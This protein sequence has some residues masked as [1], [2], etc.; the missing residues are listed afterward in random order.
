MKRTGDDEHELRVDVA[1]TGH[2]RKRLIAWKNLVGAEYL[3]S[4]C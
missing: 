1:K 2:D 4:G 3:Y